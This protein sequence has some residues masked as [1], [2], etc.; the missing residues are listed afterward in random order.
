MKLTFK[1][2]ASVGILALGSV[3]ANAGLIDNNTY[4]TDDVSG[5]DWRDI[6]GT[7]GQS[8][9][10]VSSEFGLNGAYEGWRYATGAEFNGLVNGVSGGS[11]S[12]L[13]AANFLPEIQDVS[14]ADV[15][16]GLLGVTYQNTDGVMWLGGIIGDVSEEGIHNGAL[17][18]SNDFIVSTSDYTRAHQWG[19]LD[20]HSYS[21]R[22]SFLVRSSIATSVSEPAT[23]SLL[24]LGLAG[25]GFARRQKKP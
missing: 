13:S 7:V 24:G 17:I 8:Y 3:T 19:L 11:F 25:L 2:M 6:T 16:M 18:Y 4:T 22:G 1:K 5:L 10:V 20:D 21:T 15:I 9:N 14:A 23:L 12:S